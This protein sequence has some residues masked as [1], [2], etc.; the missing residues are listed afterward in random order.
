MVK[1]RS[2]TKDSANFI[3]SEASSSDPGTVLDLSMLKCSVCMEYPRLDPNKNIRCCSNAH[4]TCSF[5]FQSLVSPSCPLCRGPLN[6]RCPGSLVSRLV[7]SNNILVSCIHGCG[8]R[9]TLDVTG[10]HEDSCIMG[11]VKCNNQGCLDQVMFG[12]MQQHR[13]NCIYRLIS[14]PSCKESFSPKDWCSGHHNCFTKLGN[15]GIL[16]C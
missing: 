8:M 13:K 12:E 2:Q 6:S 7:M 5:C 9:S 14:C 10:N 4:L 16:W 11:M 3:E 1:T 15:V